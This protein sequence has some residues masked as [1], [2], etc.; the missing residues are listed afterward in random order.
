MGEFLQR[1]SFERG[2]GQQ[3]HLVAGACLVG[4]QLGGKRCGTIR[5]QEMGVINNAP[6]E[7]RDVERGGGRSKCPDH[8]CHQQGNYPHLEL[9]FGRLGRSLLVGHREV[10]LH[11]H[12]ENVFRGQI[13]GEKAHQLIVFGHLVDVPLARH[14]DPVLGAL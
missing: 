3:R 14:G 7:R 5:R 12:F 10:R 11:I 4:G 1:L 9:D 2:Q 8:D 13:G 6:G